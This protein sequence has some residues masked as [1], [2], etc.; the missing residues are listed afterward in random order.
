MTAMSIAR[1]LKISA[2]LLCLVA[3]AAVVLAFWGDC[4]FGDQVPVAGVYQQ[5]FA[6]YNTDGASPLERQW[7]S[8]LWDGVAQFYPWRELVHRSMVKHGELPLW[9]PHQFCGAPFVGNGQS[10][11][12]YPPHW[13][14]AWFE[15]GRAMGLLNA[16][17]YFLAGLFTFLLIRTIGAGWVGA[18]LGAVVYSFGGFMV[19]WTHL[20]SLIS[21]AAWLPAGLLG[22][23]LAF[24]G[25]PL[26]GM[27]LLALALGMSL[28][29]GHFQIAAYVWLVSL[30][31]GA[32]HLVYRFA[33]RRRPGD[34]HPSPVGP[35]VALVAAV[36]L[37][38]GLGAAQLL[39]SLELSGMSPRG[40]DRV[41]PEG[42][43]FHRARALL[44]IELMTTVDPDFIGSPVRKNYPVWRIS[45]SEHCAYIGV[46][47]AV[48]VFL[49]LLLGYR[50][51]AVWLYALIGALALWTAMGGLT[52]YVYYFW[53]PKVGLA[54]G[55]SRLLS[56]FTLCAAV[57]AGLGVDALGKRTACSPTSCPPC[58]RAWPL[59]LVALALTQ[60]LPWAYQ[61]NPRTPAGQVYRP[62]ELTRHLTDLAN[63]GRV[64]EITEPEKWT[65]F[66]LPEALLPP[67]SA[68]V[69]GYCS[70]NGYDSL[71]P[72]T[73][74]RFADRVQQ[75]I[76][77]P[78][79]N[80][81]MIL[82]SRAF[83]VPICRYYVS[84]TPLLGEDELHGAERFRLV[85]SSAEGY[86]Y[87]DRTA[88]PY[89]AWRPDTEARAESAYDWESVQARRL[90]ANRVRLE[91]I[92][93]ETGQCL[94][95]EGY[96]PGWIA[97]V[98]GQ[99]QK[100]KLADETFMQLS[101][102]YGDHRVDLVYRPA[103]VEAGEFFSLLSL[104]A[105]IAV[106]V[107]ARVSRRNCPESR[108]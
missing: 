25:R 44:P 27:L 39:P 64:L 92:A 108:T 66:D 55:F 98:S 90:G 87:E 105:M 67:N 11:L 33:M 89:A 14:L 7:D 46:A 95:S 34:T 74:R 100:P 63:R 81:N 106:A 24:R 6:P 26:R 52:S 88:R 50:R 5:Q 85:Y 73:Y 80:G 107:A 68:T 61:F 28:L 41:S 4:I 37:G 35:A 42:Y 77:S 17:H 104:M 75:G 1:R 57:L 54:G 97:S 71:L 53:I 13:L 45:Y 93:A 96:F 72:T 79:A 65:L 69:Y 83:E 31:S 2:D 8:L 18:L 38:A 84:S 59:M 78:A 3:F 58:A 23:E 29:A 86:I 16:L 103:S 94:L 22:V 9:N 60:A 32:A 56:V 91:Y 82:I 10:G 101:L 20:P 76:A 19:T 40:G 15:T 30:G 99:L 70:V 36:M 48:G 12:F 49:A 102:P 47:G 62:T 43:E 51:P 21:T